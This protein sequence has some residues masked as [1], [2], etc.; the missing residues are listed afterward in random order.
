M[1]SEMPP[2]PTSELRDLARSGFE[3][4]VA[5]VPIVGGPIQVLFDAVMVPSLVKRRDNWFDQLGEMLN[6]LSQ[7]IEG[8]DPASLAD[9]EIFISAILEASR[10]AVRSHQDWK[11]DMLRNCLVNIVVGGPRQ[12]FFP[13]RY[14]RYVDD[15]SCEH[16][17]VLKYL[18]N[19][20]KWFDQS[21]TERPAVGLMSSPRTFLESANLPIG[22]DVLEVVLRDLNAEGLARTAGMTTT[23]TYEGAAQRLATAVGLALIFYVTE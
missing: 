17:L 8:F 9:N 1:T 20:L 6:R 7:R 16:F 22:A 5:A 23:M 19:P 12:D 14:L 18:S 13:E 11:L 21:G 15:L 2:F 10:I 3:M 4:G